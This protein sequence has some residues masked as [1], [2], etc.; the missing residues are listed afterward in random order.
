M[1]R[2][3]LEIL[4]PRLQY[5]FLAG[6]P[7]FLCGPLV[8]LDNLRVRTMQQISWPGVLNLMENLVYEFTAGDS[9]LHWCEVHTAKSAGRP[10]FMCPGRMQLMIGADVAYL[11]LN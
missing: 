3:E 11:W 10:E 9:D 5:E 4:P 2:V 8:H 6:S 7:N 1:S